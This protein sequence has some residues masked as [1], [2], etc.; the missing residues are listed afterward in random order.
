MGRLANKIMV[1]VILVSLGVFFMEPIAYPREV[2]IKSGTPI[3]I[4][5]EQAVSSETATA[6][7]TVRFMVTKDV[8]V[9]D[10]V[11]IKAGSEV[12]GEVSHVQK[13]G[14][15]GK[16]GELTLVVRYAQAVD[17]T[18]VPLRS[19]LSQTGEEKMAISFMLCPFI[20][21]TKGMIPAGTETKTYVDYDTKIKID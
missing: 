9:D 6:G 2:T 17:D 13:T 7:Q 19:T 11:V 16:E 12:T 15:F 3:P 10:I 1:M 21:G 20:K 8:L 5:I 4:K 14:T 18:R